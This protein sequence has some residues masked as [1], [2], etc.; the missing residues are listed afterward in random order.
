MNPRRNKVPHLISSQAPSTARPL[1]HRDDDSNTG[2]AS[3]PEAR[4]R[5]SV[6]SPPEM[7]VRRRIESR[8]YRRKPRSSLFRAAQG[9]DRLAGPS[10]DG[11]PRRESP[12]RNASPPAP[13]SRQPRRPFPGRRPGTGPS[14][15]SS[16]SKL[17]A[18]TNPHRADQA[19]RQAARVLISS[20]R[21]DAGREE[22]RRG[23]TSFLL[24]HPRV[25]C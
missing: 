17:P 3:T 5:K 21:S 7:P 12:R 2:E 19:P 22:T 11:T 15:P 4:R 23:G 14:V 24:V 8:R 10:S 6:T 16:S 9:G 13:T 18:R 25:G 20:Q 1:L